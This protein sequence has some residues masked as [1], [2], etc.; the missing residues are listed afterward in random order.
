MISRFVKVIRLRLGPPWRPDEF[1]N[2]P[3]IATWKIKF[4]TRRNESYIYTYAGYMI[5]IDITY[6]LIALL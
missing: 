3:C 2:A 6:Y 4:V 1:I 5:N